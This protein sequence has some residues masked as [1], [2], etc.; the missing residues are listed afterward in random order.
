VRARDGLSAGG[1][2]VQREREHTRARARDAAGRR[3]REGGLAGDVHGLRENVGRVPRAGTAGEAEDDR[4]EA[5]AGVKERGGR[6]GVAVGQPE[7]AQLAAR[8]SCDAHSQTVIAPRSPCR[9][10]LAGAERERAFG[11]ERESSGQRR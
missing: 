6:R 9:P 4:G 5:G 11:A 2:A 8:Q 10:E 1:R 7:L 3:E